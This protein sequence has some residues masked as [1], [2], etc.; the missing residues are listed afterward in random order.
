VL[1]VLPGRNRR[2]TSAARILLLSF[3]APEKR[4]I[5]GRDCGFIEFA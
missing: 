4:T 2:R 3:G 1:L 5:S